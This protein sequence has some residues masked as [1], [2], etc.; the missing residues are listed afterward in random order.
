MEIY[1]Y[2]CLILFFNLVVAKSQWEIAT[3]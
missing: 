1:I 3:A 2:I